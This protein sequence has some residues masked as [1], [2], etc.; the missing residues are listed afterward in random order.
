MSIIAVL[1]AA[2]ALAQPQA[3]AVQGLAIAKAAGHPGPLRV[4][5]EA[6]SELSKGFGTPIWALGVDSADG[7][8]GHVSVLLVRRG[9]YLTA[10]LQQS[11][12]AAAANPKEAAAAIV[13]DLQSQVR[14]AHD[15]RERTRLQQ[16]LHEVE[17]VTANGPITQRIALANG[18]VGYGTMLGFSAAGGTFVTALPSPDD[19]YELVVAT[20]ASLE[21]EHR[22][23]S[24][25]SAAYEQAMRTH[26]LQVSEAI[27]KAIYDDLYPPQSDT[28]DSAKKK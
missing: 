18:R 12:A 4:E 14:T 21:G 26:P 23:P 13:A 28:E 22:T 1:L 16:Q 25:Q 2:A 27:A 19:Q 24:P 11:L 10:A 15:E 9:T 6:T 8:F 17:A 7:S 20:G 5:P 3:S